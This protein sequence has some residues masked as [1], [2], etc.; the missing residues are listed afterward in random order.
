MA[1][2]S[3]PTVALWARLTSPDGTVSERAIR[4]DQRALDLRE[5]Q[6]TARDLSWLIDRVIP[7][8]VIEGGT[9]LVSVDTL[10]SL[11]MH[12][13]RIVTRTRQQASRLEAA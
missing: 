8:E 4:A 11:R 10:D 3:D 5:L 6:A 13:R 12:A 7:D 2:K 1:R 9:V